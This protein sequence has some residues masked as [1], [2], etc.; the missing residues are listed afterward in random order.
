MCWHHQLLFW[1][2]YP[3][4]IL[5]PQPPF[6][7]VY[8]DVQYIIEWAGESGEILGD[9]EIKRVFTVDLARIMLPMAGPAMLLAYTLWPTLSA[10]IHRLCDMIQS[11]AWGCV[12]EIPIYPYWSEL[13]EMGIEQDNNTSNNNSAACILMMSMMLD[14]MTAN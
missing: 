8:I 10:M 1:T 11:S 9:R 6:Y 13:W 5:A 14:F 4:S 3:N 2:L 7:Y 12:A